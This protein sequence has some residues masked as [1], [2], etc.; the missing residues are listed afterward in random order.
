MNKIMLLGVAILAVASFVLSD[1]VF[2]KDGKTYEGKATKA[3]GKVIVETKDGRVEVK[4]DN[5]LLIS[6]PEDLVP[7]TAPA[8]TPVSL[9]V[10]S[11]TP[12]PSI[13]VS[14]FFSSV[15]PKGIEQPESAVFL[16]MRKIQAAANEPM[17][18]DAVV[19]FDGWRAAAHDRRRK[20]GNDW[21]PADT[22]V[23]MKKTHSAAIADA[24]ASFK[25]IK[26]TASATNPAQVKALEDENKKFKAQGVAKL[27]H[28]A[29]AWPDKTLREFLIGDAE[30]INGNYTLAERYF[31]QCR[32][33]CP[34]VAAF[35]QGQAMAALEL[36]ERQL[37]AVAY[38]IEAVKLCP[39]SAELFKQLNDA[40]SKV[41]GTRLSNPA[42]L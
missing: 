11:P 13:G 33:G 36:T 31:F 41:P 9:P 23:R 10:V 26:K 12:A 34:L 14:R 4:E 22:F 16:M 24:A 40:M 37:D 28:A 2:T 20:F 19:E 1:T 3:P 35:W 8:S 15:L 18:A 32:T 17:P 25:Q 30:T 29:D 42:Y 39:A 38:F 7:L 6:R 21:I 5:I 27:R